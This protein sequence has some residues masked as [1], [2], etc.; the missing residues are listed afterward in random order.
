MKLKTPFISVIGFVALFFSSCS[1]N[2]PVDHINEEVPIEEVI[3]IPIVIHVVN[4]TP[5]P[6]TISDE[7]I[8]SQIDVLNQDFG[9]KN[10][11][12][13]KTPGEFINLVADVDIEFYLATTNPDGNPTTG[14][15][16][17]ESEVTGF[18][19]RD[20]PIN[21][22]KLYFTDK[23]GQDPWP[24]DS[25]LNIWISDLSNRNGELALAGY[26]QFPGGDPRSDGVVIDPRVFG[27]LPPLEPSRKLG[28]T[29][30]HEIGHWLN[31]KHIYGEDGDC[32]N[33]D[34]VDDTPK[35]RSSYS[36]NPIHPKN[37]CES[38]DLFMNFMDGVND[39]SMY[40]FTK[41]QKERIR[42]NFN[43][44]GLRR[45]LYNNVREK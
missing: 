26:A 45:A 25:Y 22:L 41:G 15:I 40:M 28:R 5:D 35:Q 9:K 30:T 14:I 27:T 16:R 42:S 6:F 13:I 24:I 44:N 20:A 43:P 4:Y 36:G 7:K 38:T 17:T 11:D 18:D 3:K 8:R 37:S 21:E 34:L 31:L 2:P 33:G 23:G 29:A 39:E 12:Y 32:K 10:S 19:G 1:N